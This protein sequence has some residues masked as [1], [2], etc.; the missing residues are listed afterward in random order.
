MALQLFEA[1]SA[2]GALLEEADPLGSRK[3]MGWTHVIALR[4][5]KESKYE[6]TEF[7]AMLRT[8]VGKLRPPPD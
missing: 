7:V 2:V 3:D 4:E 1:A 5:A 6:A 8:S